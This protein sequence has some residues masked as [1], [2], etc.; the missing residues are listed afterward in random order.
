LSQ[1]KE[2]AEI[3]GLK[4][5]YSTNDTGIV[6]FDFTIGIER[7]IED[8]PTPEEIWSCL[9]S[10]DPLHEPAKKKLLTPAMGNIVKTVS[11][12]LFHGVRIHLV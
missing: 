8:F 11:N 3:L 1:A 6:E 7:S 12:F 10:K 9:N 5:A 4:F 2:Y